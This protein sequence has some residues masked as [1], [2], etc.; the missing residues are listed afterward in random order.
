M[1]KLKTAVV[2]TAFALGALVSA[3]AMAQGKGEKSL[4]LNG[5]Y[6]TYNNSGYVGVGFQY[7]FADHFR[8]APDISYVFRHEDKSALA[9]SAD[10]HFPFRLAKGFGIYPLLGLTFNN[11]TVN[12][13]ERK[14]NWSRF[15]GDFG[16]GFD[17][18][19]TSSFKLSLQGKFSWMK[20]TSGGFFGLGFHYLF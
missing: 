5:G 20:D 15:G 14:E 9:I 17:I 3:P 13:S 1:G 11:W 16:M 4:G 12:T 19:F 8:L 18:Y 2:A 6:A 10:M 7:A